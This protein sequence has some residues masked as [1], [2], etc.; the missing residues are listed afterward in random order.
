MPTSTAASYARVDAVKQRILAEL[1]GGSTELKAAL[2]AAMQCVV[3]L[4]HA[5]ELDAAADMQQTLFDS[6]TSGSGV[7]VHAETSGNA[8]HADVA[9][10]ILGFG[11]SS[12]GV[13]QSVVHAYQRLQP[14]WKYVVTSACGIAFEE[15][16]AGR[17]ALDTQ[18]ERII[19]ELAGAR[20]IVAHI[21]S[22]NGHGLWGNLLHRKGKAVRPRVGAVIYDCSCPAMHLGSP[23]NWTGGEIR[24]VILATV[25][26]Q[27][28]A[29]QL[30]VTDPST[31]G[32][33]LGRNSRELRASPRHTHTHSPRPPTSSALFSLMA[34]HCACC[35][36][37]ARACRGLGRVSLP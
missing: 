14:T 37:D 33:Q 16:D 6:I 35:R 36:C 1:C 27:V 7:L 10:L 4:M 13:L 34:L 5:G 25:W 28:M 11:G 26:M 24:A 8:A 21:M 29:L 19:V 31:P 22:N 3:D 17:A 23:S 2:Q 20:K 32:R 9:V 30:Q 18:L 12:V 15:T